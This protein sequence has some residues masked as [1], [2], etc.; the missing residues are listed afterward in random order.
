M[1]SFA[2]RIKELR[3]EKGMTQKEFSE[4]VDVAFTTVS[5]W[6]RGIRK[7]D[8]P[9]LEEIADKCNV[10]L[11]YLLGESDDKSPP[12]IPSN[13][14]LGRWSI[15][16][17]DADLTHLATLLVQLS[18]ESREIITGAINAAYKSDRRRGRLRPA[19]E[20][21]VQIQSRCLLQKK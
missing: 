5:V 2:E 4:Y 16:E 10:T 15:E 12:E 7:P 20:R 14:D 3:Q 8:F 19:D 18:D 21:I 11:L 1:A 13:E 17:D 9:K 6:E